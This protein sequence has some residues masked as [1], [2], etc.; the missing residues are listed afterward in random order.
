MTQQ[1]ISNAIS[2]IS[3]A[4]RARPDGAITGAQVHSLIQTVA[5]DLNIREIVGMPTGP[6]ALSKFITDHLSDALDR[7]GN[8]GGD[9]LY[10][11]SGHNHTSQVSRETSDIWRTFVSPRA[12][13]SVVY[14]CEKKKLRLVEP[15]AVQGE[16]L[17]EIPKVS[18]QEHDTIRK[19][20][21]D[22]LDPGLAEE[23]REVTDSDTEF[24]TWIG[25]LRADFPSVYRAWGNFR[26]QRLL[27][28][29][30]DRANAHEIDEGDREGLVSQIRSAHFA[31]YDGS[32]ELNI[33]TGPK[34]TTK[35]TPQARFN[36]SSN[37]LED[38]RALVHRAVDLM[39]HD[40]L[41]SIKL[42]LGVVLDAIQ[43]RD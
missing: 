20:F 13:L 40:E 35:W 19:E 36:K 17:I 1:T 6:G 33:Q 31:A 38:A 26:K 15:D 34:L 43:K 16:D 11:I 21:V 12:S 25:V 24:Q 30:L 32:K 9:V 37:E 8:H 29:F 28:L 27:S 23:L 5:P 2:A 39:A 18:L 3:A 41:R 22:S 42:P 7:I 10:G 14:D 4:L